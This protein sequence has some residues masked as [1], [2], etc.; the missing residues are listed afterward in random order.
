[1]R[2]TTIFQPGDLVL[3]AFP[4][5]ESAQSK[6]RPALVL[7]DSGDDDIVVARVTTQM[8]RTPHDGLLAD[9][10]GAGLLALS[11]VRL[12]KLATLGKAIV[13]RRFG[14]IGSG[15]RQQVAAVLRGLYGTW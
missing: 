12:H 15:D 10:Q 13:R 8:A 7:L 11:V 3:V 1:M 6:Y 2:A 9:W 5:V 14:Q 4:Y